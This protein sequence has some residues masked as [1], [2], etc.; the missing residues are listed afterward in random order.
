MGFLNSKQPSDK[1]IDLLSDEKNIFIQTHDFPDPDAIAAAF[2]LQY[3]LKQKEIEAKI[4]YEGELQTNPVQS[5]IKTLG[6]SLHKRDEVTLRDDDKIII[7]DGCKGN[8]NVTIKQGKVI[9]VIDHHQGGEPSEV[10]F[11]DI[12]NDYGSCSTI[13]A[14][15]MEEQQLDLTSGIATALATGIHVDTDSFRRRTTAKDLQAFNFLFNKIDNNL[16][17]SI[18]R[19]N[20]FE[21]ELAIYE[22]AIKTAKLS[23]KFAFCYYSGECSQNL[24][25]IIA[26]FFLAI[27]EIEFVALCALSDNKIIFSTR[28]E[29]RQWNTALIITNVLE[30]LGTGGG[31]KDMAGGVIKDVALFNEAE[32]YQRFK[33]QLGI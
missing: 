16:L 17:G 6:I 26:D 32:I 1:L 10:P 22:Q 11:V 4:I 28:S 29:N 3:L 14:L 20:I 33:Q 19:N 31:H 24:L 21:Q 9:A 15:Y 8:H 27:K 7:V 25:G 12:R 13:I 30:G 18:L 2:G 23:N 5:M